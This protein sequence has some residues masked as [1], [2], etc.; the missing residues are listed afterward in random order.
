MHPN[1][2]FRQASRET[3]LDFARARGFGVLTTSGDDGPMMSHIPFL[4]SE[5][6]AFAEFHLVRSNPIARGDVTRAALVVSGP[7][8]YVSPDWYGVPDQVPTWN[9]VAV[10]LRGHIERLGPEH[11]R[12]VLDR[13]SA[14]FESELLPKTPWN[15]D[16]MTD[17]VLEKMMRMIVPFRLVIE[18]VEG[19]H[20]LGQNKPDAVRVAAANEMRA[21][22]IGYE[23]RL[24]ADLMS[25]LND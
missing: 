6:G 9:Y 21:H 24:L 22:R 2:T 4:V 13:L 11:L 25:Q 12:G 16:K 7:D 14:R 20:K 15:A 3:N 8:G 5:D 23:T 1:Q 18:T 19:T 10:H 17:D